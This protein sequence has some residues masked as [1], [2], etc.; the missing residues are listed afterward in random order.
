MGDD[1]KTPPKD[2]GPLHTLLVRACPPHARKRE[3]KRGKWTYYEDPKGSFKSLPLL[4]KKLGMTAWGVQKWCQDNHLPAKRATQIVD[5]NPDE[6]S[7]A[8]FSPFVYM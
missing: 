3:G 4:A 7:L 1:A 2:Y 5:L 6:V 8:E